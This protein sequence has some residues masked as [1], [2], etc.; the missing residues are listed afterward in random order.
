VWSRPAET[1]FG[2]SEA[3]AL[4]QTLSDLGLAPEG[5]EGLLMTQ[6]AF[7]GKPWDGTYPISTKSGEVVYVR[8]RATPRWGEDG[9]VA[10]VALQCRNS[11]QPTEQH[12][13]SAARIA[14][15]SD[16]GTALG[17]SLNLSRTL[18]DLGGLFVPAFADH[19]IIDL[20]DE[21]GA[22]G[23]VPPMRPASTTPTRGSPTV[24]CRLSS[25]AP[26]ARA[27]SAGRS[28]PGTCPRT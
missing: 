18:K 2:W 3:D 7:A 8:F 13:R 15:L 11:L 5:S 24:R 27:M 4:E 25:G 19:C 21:E 22:L 14:L 28:L 16:A 9:S 1:L 6:R 23:L 20:Y 12:E 17:G 26:G 10:G